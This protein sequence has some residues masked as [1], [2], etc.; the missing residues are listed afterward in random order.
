MPILGVDHEPTTG[1][2]S[3]DFGIAPRDDRRTAIDEQPALWVREVVLNINHDE[4]SARAIC[5]HGPSLLNSDVGA[6]NGVASLGY[7]VR[8]ITEGILF[9]DHYQLTMAQLY[10]QSG[11]AERPAQFEHF[12]R[13]YPD[14]GM[15]QAGYC[16]TAGLEPL[17]DWMGEVRFGDAERQA[18]ASIRTPRG[19]RIFGDEFLDWL[20]DAGGFGQVSLRAVPE[21]RVV[22]A[23]V[24][25][26]IAE[27]PLAMAQILET[28]LLNHLNFATLIATKASRVVE[29]AAGG[30]VIEF[31]LRRAPG[32]GG[33]AAT[34][35]S[36]IGGA[37]SS[38][39]FGMTQS[40]GITP[41]GTHAHSMV[42]VF[43]AIRGGELEAFRAYAETYPDDCLLLVDTIDTLESG[44][45]NAITV[46]EELRKK[47]HEPVGIRLDSGDLAHL[48]VRSARLLDDAGFG[49]TRIVLS[50]GLDELT[51]WQVKNQIALEAPQYGLDADS[52]VSRLVHGV[53]SKLVTS[54]GDSSLGGVYKTVA[55]GGDDGGWVPAIKISDTPEKVQNPGA[56]RVW[57]IYDER[58]FAT[59]DVLGLADEQLDITETIYLRHPTLPGLTRALAPSEMSEIEELLVAVLEKGRRVRKP[60]GIDEARNHRQTDIARLDPGV[61]RLVNPHRYHVSLTAA[62]GELKRELVAGYAD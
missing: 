20:C 19:A 45:P 50:S 32:F 57:R 14:Y 35:S 4:C 9:T 17:L 47:G 8:D 18:M 43:M 39:N 52:V 37:V 29:A 25:I 2:R 41:S 54:D 42:Q 3:H 38:S 56:K 27:A 53:G 13:S 6:W 46:F 22:H 5:V 40:L 55:V 34:R 1:E 21:G 33:N 62:L 61:K 59:A 11:L 15:H 49:D 30:S 48:A 60:Q 26:V 31:G 36:L 58:G 51:I 10:Y 23:N 16:I 12:F 28:P 44:V 7:T 24:P